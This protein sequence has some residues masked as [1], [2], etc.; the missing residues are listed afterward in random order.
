MRK[1]NFLLF[2]FYIFSNGLFLLRLSYKKKQQ[3]KYLLDEEG[4]KQKR[5]VK[6]LHLRSTNLSVTFK[7]HHF[8]VDLTILSGVLFCWNIYTLTPSINYVSIFI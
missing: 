6:D 4:V 3:T 7:V 1:R 2:L 8:V 5:G